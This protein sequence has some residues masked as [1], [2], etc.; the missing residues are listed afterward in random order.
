[1]SI[2]NMW[3]VILNTTPYRKEPGLL[4]EMAASRATAGNSN[5]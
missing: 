1:M 2:T 3:L 4:R 5:N